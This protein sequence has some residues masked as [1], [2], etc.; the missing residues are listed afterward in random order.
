MW[1][2]RR[3]DQ[4]KLNIRLRMKNDHIYNK[5]PPVKSLNTAQYAIH[6]TTSPVPLRGEKLGRPRG[7][8]RAFILKA[9][10]GSD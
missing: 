10:V 4:R 8:V 1:S 7:E 2:T 9:N 3:R 5:V 6:D